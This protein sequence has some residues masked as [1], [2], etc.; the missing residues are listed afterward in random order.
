MPMPLP[1]PPPKPPFPPPAP[2]PC[3]RDPRATYPDG[4]PTLGA[5]G[6]EL[7]GSTSHVLTGLT[8]SDFTAGFTM[9]FR[10]TIKQ[11]VDYQRVFQFSENAADSG[12][13]MFADLGNN[14]VSNGWRTFQYVVSPNPYYRMNHGYWDYN[15]HIYAFVIGPSVGPSSYKDG[16]LFAGT[17]TGGTG[18]GWGSNSLASWAT[19]LEVGKRN[20][21]WQADVKWMGAWN[22]E[23]SASQLAQVSDPARSAT[24][25]TALHSPIWFQDYTC[26]APVG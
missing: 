26:A 10:A 3:V 24:E 17:W 12:N 23:L 16:Q 6:L 20:Y 13:R 4:A 18:N 8:G 5:N 7:D 15:E 2:P 1:P 19:L 14:G 21:N 25:V 22:A 9:A 11:T